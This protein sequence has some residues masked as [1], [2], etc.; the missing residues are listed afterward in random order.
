MFIPFNEN[1]LILGKKKFLRD[2]FKKQKRDLWLIKT[3][4]GIDGKFDTKSC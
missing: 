2:F 4:G 3:I 1:P